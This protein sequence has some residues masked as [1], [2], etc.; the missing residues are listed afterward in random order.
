MLDRLML[1]GLSFIIIDVETEIVQGHGHRLWE[2]V[3]RGDRGLRKY[4]YNSAFLS[5]NLSTVIR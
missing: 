2:V 1:I 4:H 5:G 3:G